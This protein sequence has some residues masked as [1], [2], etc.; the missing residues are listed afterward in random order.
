MV[1]REIRKQ[2]AGLD[3]EGF[4]QFDDVLQGYVPF[5]ALHSANI[6]AVQARPLGQ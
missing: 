2:V 4:C 1:S 5:A 6:V 3:G